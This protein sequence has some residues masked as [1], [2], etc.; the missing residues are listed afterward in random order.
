M[1]SFSYALTEEDYYEYNKFYIANMPAQKRRLA[2]ARW[3]VPVMFLFLSLITKVIIDEFVVQAAVWATL[4]VGAVLWLIFFWSIMNRQLR[5]N[6]KKLKKN[7]RLVYDKPISMLFRE[8]Y[9][10]TS[11]PESSENNAYSMIERVCV[12][13]VAVYLFI[14]ANSAHIVP[15]RAFE[16]DGEKQS[17]LEFVAAKTT[18]V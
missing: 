7:G 13:E 5:K 16:S 18:K 15:N 8:D 11:T 4:L 14:G 1:F 6:I 3:Y 17:F 12:G 2:F 9:I 10:M